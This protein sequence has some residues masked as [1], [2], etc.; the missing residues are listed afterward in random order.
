MTSFETRVLA[1]LSTLKAQM[2]SVVG[3]MQ[4]GRLMTL[5]KRVQEQEIYLQRTRG[6]AAACGVLVT[7]ANLAIDYWRH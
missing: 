1:D 4:P 2:E 5:E 6:F 3:G 7:L